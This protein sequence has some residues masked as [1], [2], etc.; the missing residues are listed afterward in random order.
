MSNNVI[1]AAVVSLAFAFASVLPVAA[2]KPSKK[3]TD[4]TT[5]TTTYYES[6]AD[7]CAEFDPSNP[8]CTTH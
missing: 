2:A 4:Q 7:T 8:D 1:I 6:G 5:T 3:T